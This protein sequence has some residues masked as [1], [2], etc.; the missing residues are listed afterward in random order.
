MPCDQIPSWSQ[1]IPQINDNRPVPP[2]AEHELEVVTALQNLS[3]TVIANAASRSLARFVN[4]PYSNVLCLM[5]SRIKARPEFKSSFT[6]PQ[7]LYRALHI[8]STQRYRLPVRRYILDLFNLELNPQLVNALNTAADDLRAPPTYKPP[9]TDSIRLSVFGRIGKSR[10]ASESD[11]SDEEDAQN[12]PTH[13]NKPPDERPI[14]SLR[15]VSTVI[16]FAV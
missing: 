13:Q 9:R 6:S 1:H 5:T 16:G 12:I 15:P 11:E 2:T 8:I 14:L 7:M 3:N 4:A 10:H